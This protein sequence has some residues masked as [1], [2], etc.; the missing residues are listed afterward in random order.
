MQQCFGS[1]STD[2]LSTGAVIN[3][4]MAVEQQQSLIG[5]YKVIAASVLCVADV[6]CVCG[7]EDFQGQNAYSCPFQDVE[8]QSF[9]TLS[10]A[11]QA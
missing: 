6:L 4:R 8:L 7:Q 1:G 3:L 2:C 9:L 10:G 11:L 5:S